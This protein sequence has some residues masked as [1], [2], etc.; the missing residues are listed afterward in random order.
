MKDVSSWFGVESLEIAPTKTDSGYKRKVD[1]KA[2]ACA[3]VSNVYRKT[4]NTTSANKYSFLTC[5]GLMRVLLNKDRGYTRNIDY[6]AFA[7]SEVIN[8]DRKTAN[9]ASAGKYLFLT[10][11]G[12]A[13][14]VR[15]KKQ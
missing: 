7:C 2:F 8:D 13:R 5:Q 15:D 9:T 12:L 6:K 10:C 11:A 14:F 3:E 1:Y 4:T